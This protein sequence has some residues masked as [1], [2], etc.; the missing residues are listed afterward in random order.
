MS[1]KAS[2][3]PLRVL[4][5][6]GLGRSGST[7]LERLLSELPGV[8]GMGEVV[9]LWQRGLVDN[10]KCA[11]GAAF[12]D[13]PFW[14]KVGETAFGGWKDLDIEEFRA[15]KESI[16]RTRFVPALARARLAGDTRRRLTAYDDVYRRLYDAV[17]DVSG[18]EVLVDSSK[19]ISLAFCLRWSEAID[20]RVVHVVRD[21]RAVAHSW[22][23]TVIRPEAGVRSA[24]GAH[25]ARWSPAKTALHWNAQNFGFGLLARRGVPT[26]RVRYEDFVRSPAVTLREIAAFAALGETV[27]LPFT[28]ERSVE[29]SPNHQ[30]AGNPLR[31]RTGRIELRADEAWRSELGVLRRYTVAGLTLPL[32]AGYGYLTGDR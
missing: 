16:D 25:M 9:H 17:R 15:L 13:C 31:F 21:P 1:D 10:E 18:C 30:V 23:K 3:A 2:E 26:M 19:H 28:E 20:L 4:F 32:L 14:R 6:G 11:C 5:V 12:H 27:P 24:E 7:L 8:C 22:A 29:L